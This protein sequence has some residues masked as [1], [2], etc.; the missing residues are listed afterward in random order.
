MIFQFFSKLHHMHLLS[1]LFAGRQVAGHAL[2]EGGSLLNLA[3]Y[4]EVNLFITQAF[5]SKDHRPGD[6]PND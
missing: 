3:F 5:G 2:M 6:K 1:T 4:K